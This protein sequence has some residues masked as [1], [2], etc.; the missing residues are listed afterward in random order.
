MLFLI[1]LVHHYIKLP[2]LF[3]ITFIALAFAHVVIGI[4]YIKGDYSSVA[5]GDNTTYPGEKYFMWI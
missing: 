4:S 2:C 5:D 1:F 3:G